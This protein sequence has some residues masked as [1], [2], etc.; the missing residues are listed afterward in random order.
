MSILAIILILILLG[1]LGAGY[2]YAGRPGYW[3]AGWPLGGVLGVV[4]VVVLILALL[5]RF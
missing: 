4:L 2:P 1:G 3:G 5:G